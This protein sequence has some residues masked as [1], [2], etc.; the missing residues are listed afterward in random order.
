[1]KL[2]NFLD[3]CSGHL[4]HKWESVILYPGICGDGAGGCWAGHFYRKCTRC[5]EVI[6]EGIWAAD[7]V[8]GGKAWHRMR[9]AHV[10]ELREIGL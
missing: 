2:P 6:S 10:S 9:D 8:D 1:M 7:E 5:G 4:V 3:R